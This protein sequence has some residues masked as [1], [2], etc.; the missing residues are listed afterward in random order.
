MAAENATL[1]SRKEFKKTPADQHKYWE[2]ELNSSNK[3]LKEFH[4]Q[5]TNVVNRYRGGKVKDTDLGSDDSF[6]LNLYHSNTNTLLSTMYGSIPKVRAFRTHNDPKDDVGRVA[7]NILERLLNNDIQVNGEEYDTVM[8]A[9]LQDR[10]IPG[11]GCAKVRYKAT[12]GTEPNPLGGD[13]LKVLTNEVAP[14]E[15]I[16]WRDVRWGWSRTFKDIP[17]I[18]FRSYLKKDEVEARFGE[19][20]AKSLEYKAQSVTEK[21]DGKDDSDTDGPWQVAEIWEIWDKVKRQIHWYCPSYDKLIESKSDFLGLAGFYPCPPLFLANCTTSHYIPR[22]DF[23]IAQDLYNE[24]D[25]LQTRISIITQAV[26]VVGLYDSGTEE[27][28]R[29][30]NEG[31][32]NDLIPVEK[33]AMFSE[34]GGIDGVIDWFPVKDVVESLAKLREVRDE[35]IGLLQQVTG[36][37]DFMRGQLSGQYEGVGQ[38]QMKA[39]FGSTRI[40]AL[41]D[42]FAKFASDLLQIK[43]EVICRHYEP[44]RISAL[45]DVQSMNEQDPKI[46]LQAIQLLKNFSSAR[47]RVEVKAESMAMVDFAAKQAE[48]TEFL[49]ALATFMQSASPLMEAV[50]GATP[51]LLQLLQWGL[52]GFKGSKDIEGVLDK[53]I[54]EASQQGQNDKPDPEKVKGEMAMQ[55]QQMKHQQAMQL[56]QLKT[57]NKQA[58]M[59]ADLQAD[60]AKIQADMQADIEQIMIKA[61]ADAD[62]EY[63]TSEIN[64]QQQMAGVAAEIQKMTLQTELKIQEI[65][66]A[67]QTKMKEISRAKVD[68]GSGNGEAD[69]S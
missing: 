32:D 13:D 61:Q 69:S 42:E 37:A 50:P 2:Q 56:E 60:I 55:L 18:A 65:M 68:T 63:A 46:I 26:K 41:Q 49:T 5:G 11:L 66:A 17:W 43:A 8:R 30:F 62:T 33:W 10:L 1:E 59:Q 36:M 39:N 28:G 4:K 24:I 14:S 15:Y 22:S 7:A 25:Q 29:M 35:T 12:F 23:H 40:Q 21:E 58:E 54:D 38:T 9:A 53:A 16:H 67:H 34:K 51:Y 45:A 48:R 19:E 47:L 31:M 6:Q 20:A 3:M 64:A 57:Q 52:A 44:E 27:I